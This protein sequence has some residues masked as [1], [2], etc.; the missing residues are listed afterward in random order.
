MLA[1]LNKVV[2]AVEA[3]VPTF[4]NAV[5]PSLA[6]YLNQTTQDALYRQARTLNKIEYNQEAIDLVTRQNDLE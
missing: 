4:E 5:Y 3:D 2:P 1:V 6:Q